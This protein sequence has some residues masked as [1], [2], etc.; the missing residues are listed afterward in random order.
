MPVSLE[1]ATFFCRALHGDRA[2]RD[3]GLSIVIWSTPS[4][5]SSFHPT[6]EAAAEAAMERCGSNE[7]VFL[8]MGLVRGLETSG[9]RGRRDDIVAITGL[10]GDVDIGSADVPKRCA[11][12]RSTE[13]AVALAGAIGVAPSLIVHSGHGIQ[14]YWL[15][16]E[17]WFLP[18]ESERA[19][20]ADA[21]RGW[22]LTLQGL[23]R[24]RG[25]AIDPVGD[26]A[27]VM[28]VAGTMNFKCPERPVPARLI[29]PEQYSRDVARYP[30]DELL[31][32]IRTPAGRVAQEPLIQPGEPALIPPDEARRAELASR[33][34]MLRQSSPEFDRTWTRQ[35]R[36]ASGRDS[37]SEYDLSLASQLASAGFGDADIARI[38]FMWREEHGERPEKALRGDY[39]ARTI[40]KARESLAANC[41]FIRQVH[42]HDDRA[43]TR[44]RSGPTRARGRWLR[45][46]EQV[47][48]RTQQ[49]D[50][51]LLVCA[52]PRALGPPG[53]APPVASGAGHFE[54]VPFARGRRA[55]TR[56]TVR[57]LDRHR[58][59]R[60][61]PGRPSGKLRKTAEKLSGVSR[62]DNSPRIADPRGPHAPPPRR[63][64]PTRA[65]SIGRGGETS[66]EPFGRGACPPARARVP[67]PAREAGVPQTPRAYG[68]GQA[69]ARWARPAHRRSTTTGKSWV[70]SRR[71]AGRISSSGC[72]DGF[73]RDWT[74]TGWASEGFRTRS[75]GDGPHRCRGGAVLVNLTTLALFWVGAFVPAGCGGE[76]GEPGLATREPSFISPGGPR[77]GTFRRRARAYRR[78]TETSPS[79]PMRADAPAIVTAITSPARDT[80]TSSGLAPFGNG[81]MTTRNAPAPRRRRMC[82]RSP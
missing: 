81:T 7:N 32:R 59:G 11:L 79:R 37:A 40:G 46:A 70:S 49:E 54:P 5:R 29:L 1:E 26:L 43:E 67:G 52:A 60:P 68:Q 71:A 42:R 31:S 65:A 64:P 19:R 8:G 75:S 55:R 13:E 24:D 51:G 80:A 53:F 56:P 34:R 16:A 17:P 21:V 4:K 50:G 39:I 62:S 3:A 38:L 63:H 25:W 6:P 73:W 41:S 66:A 48:A 47:R 76:E 22:V 61:A 36:F 72:P 15:F 45:A 12:P 14:P 78:P 2:I 30:R 69:R 18:D 82:C 57:P 9:R 20:A 77:S 35:R 58:R 27:R 44:R 10:W 23:A 33:L 28:R 74:S